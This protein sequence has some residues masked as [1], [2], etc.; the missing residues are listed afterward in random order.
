MKILS[1]VVLITLSL[2]ISSTAIAKAMAQPEVTL[3]MYD[4]KT[5][6]SVGTITLI[7][8]KYGLMI[9]PN[10]T[11]LTPG[12]H[13][14][15]IHEN[16]S[17]ADGGMAAGGHL[18][19][20]NT[21]THKGP[22]KDGHLGDLPSIYADQNGKVVLPVFAP[23]LTLKDAINHAIIIHDKGDSYSDEPEKLGGGGARVACGVV[24]VNK[25][26]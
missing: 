16:P 8:E 13:G 1:K 2:V 15:H 22:Y 25:K 9:S 23:K 14:I 19:P 10:I 6:Q 24:S 20:H 4:T 12:V 11:G 18:D 5:N 3:T 17:C 21:G 26:Q 7:Q